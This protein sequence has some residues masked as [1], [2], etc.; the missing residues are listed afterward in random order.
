MKV[1]N[2]F[3]PDKAQRESEKSVEETYKLLQAQYLSE[4]LAVQNKQA[5]VS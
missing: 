4:K 5:A 2:F 3:S 1:R